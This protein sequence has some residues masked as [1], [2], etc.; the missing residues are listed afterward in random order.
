MVMLVLAPTLAL[1]QGKTVR[2]IELPKQ[3][4]EVI[5]PTA[6]SL[7]ET[8]MDEKPVG[9]KPLTAEMHKQLQ[10]ACSQAKPKVAKTMGDGN[11]CISYVQ[12]H[13]GPVDF[14]LFDDKQQVA[15]TIVPAADTQGTMCLNAGAEEY[16]GNLEWVMAMDARGFHSIRHSSSIRSAAKAAKR[17]EK[18]TISL[19]LMGAECEHY[20]KQ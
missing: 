9:L 11:M 3:S 15:R 12:R 18:G 20:Q 14:C 10:D 16:A 6:E 1:A 7:P 2:Q 4:D 5:P 13:A 19:C 17:G 8:N